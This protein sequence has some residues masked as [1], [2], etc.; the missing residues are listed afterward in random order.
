MENGVEAAV[1]GSDS[2]FEEAESMFVF[3]GSRA[4]QG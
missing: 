2:E 3:I 1:N 4:R